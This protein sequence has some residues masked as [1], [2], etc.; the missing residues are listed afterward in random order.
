MI[1]GPF[2]VF[3]PCSSGIWICCFLL[4]TVLFGES[5]IRSAL[6]SL[7]QHAH[8]SV[9]IATDQFAPS[10]QNLEDGQHALASGIVAESP[11]SA[12]DLEQLLQR[13]LVFLRHYL[14]GGEP[15]ACQRLAAHKVMSEE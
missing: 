12:H 4:P 15:L 14:V 2:R 11:V 1:D 3:T 13:G 7:V 6:C 8:H 9:S 5:F 10:T